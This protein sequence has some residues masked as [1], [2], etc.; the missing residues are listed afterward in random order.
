MKKK[1]LYGFLGLIAFC[2]LVSN[3]GGSTSNETVDT[4]STKN[5]SVS[6]P[7]KDSVLWQRREEIDP[8]DDSKT[9]FSSL[10]SENYVNL[11]FPYEGDTYARFCVRSSK[12]YGLD[13][14]FSIDRGQ[15]SGREYN[16]NNYI[17]VR[18]DNKPA[19]KFYFN[20]AADGS[21]EVVFLSNPRSFIKKAKVAHKILAETE[22][23]QN[24]VPRW[25]FVCDKP[26]EWE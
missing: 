16:G 22:V 24:G 23:Y 25:T 19:Q 12:K 26:L 20:N 13:V 2:W 15:L 8:M 3:C 11:D 4:D 1:F 14:I 18:F 6:E 7:K 10:S 17:L 9:I 5:E 21:S